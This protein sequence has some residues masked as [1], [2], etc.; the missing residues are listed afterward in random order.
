MLKPTTTK[1]E[2]PSSTPMTHMME[3]ENNSYKLSSDLHMH[4]VACV[5]AHLPIPHTWLGMM[6]QLESQ[7]M[8]VRGTRISVRIASKT[9]S[10]NEWMEDK[11]KNHIQLNRSKS[12]CQIITHTAHTHKTTSQKQKSPQITLSSYCNMETVYWLNRKRKNLA[13]HGCTV[14]ALWRKMQRQAGLQAGGQP[15]LYSQFHANEG[16]IANFVFL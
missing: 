11:K 7:C 9:L 13:T 10:K 3:A 2:G 6:A 15:H 8:E 16:Y 5:Q 1:S 4:T 14:L 12:N